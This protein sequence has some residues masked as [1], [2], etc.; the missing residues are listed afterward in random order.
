MKLDNQTGWL[1]EIRHFPSPYFNKRSN[2]K[3]INLLVIHNISLPP[4][5]FGTPYIEQ[6]FAGQLDK[7]THPYF[8]Q[9][10]TEVS[11]HFL[12]NRAGK[13]VQFVSVYDKAWHAGKS[14]FA[15]RD[16]CNDYSLGIELEGSNFVPFETIQYKKLV[17]LIVLLTQHFP[18]ITLERIVGHETIAPGRKTDPGPYFDWQLLRATLRQHGLK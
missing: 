15:G 10:N 6:M 2:N 12:I 4:N 8:A 13:I 18:A 16:H 7:T 11:A 17:A 9:I 14:S 5:E 1:T 3:D